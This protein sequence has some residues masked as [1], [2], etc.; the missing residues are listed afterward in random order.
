MG[1]IRNNVQLIGNLGQDPI[2]AEL[3][4]GRKVARFTLATN[5][6]FKDSKEE[7]QK[8]T[9]W[10]NIVAWGKTA[11]IVEKFA[12]KGKEIAVTGKLKSRSYTPD[13]GIQRHITEVEARE[14]LL[15]G[16]H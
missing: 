13:D 14:I 4:N 3:E 5:V 1:I 10:H 12:A 8:E 16:N 11:E 9:N 2:I 6:Y 15:L 7:K